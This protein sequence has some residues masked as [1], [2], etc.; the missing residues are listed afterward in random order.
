MEQ[1][2]KSKKLFDVNGKTFSDGLTG[3]D[4]SGIMS[5]NLSPYSKKDWYKKLYRKMGAD[6]WLP[7]KFSLIDDKTQWATLMPEYKTAY[8]KILAFLI[9]LDSI[10]SYNPHHLAEHISDPA[11]S[12]LLLFQSFQESIHSQSYSY[13]VDS[14]IGSID[15]QKEVYDLWRK[16]PILF[17]RN[18]VIANIYQEFIDNSTDL[19]FVKSIIGNYI[20]EGLFFYNGFKFFYMLENKGLMK[21][22]ASIIKLIN[23]DEISHLMLY[24]N[25][26][27]ELRKN[28]R[29][30]KYLK[31]ELF[32]EMF[33]QA[34]DLEERFSLSALSDCIGFGEKM[35]TGYTR[36]LVN[37]RL[38]NIG[39][40]NNPWKDYTINPYNHI[41]YD[42]DVNIPATENVFISTTTTYVKADTM[43]G[44][45]DLLQ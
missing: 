14:V 40:V 4:P 18:Q 38:S 10:Q 44:W 9:F 30:A 16:D 24:Q 11:V 17:E 1:Y 3:Y 19:N 20:L 22:T 42:E 36:F 7:E 31:P 43:S 33:G 12:L 23:R 26:I 32:Y 28:E 5:I 41:E 15:D 35:I 13:I 25:L 29:F 45:D 39:L 34:L 6:F 21:G 2:L 37:K 27:D 8:K